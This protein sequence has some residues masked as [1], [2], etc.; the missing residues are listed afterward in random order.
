[1]S[2]HPGGLRELDKHSKN[3]FDRDL[4]LFKFD[5][6]SVEYEVIL[7]DIETAGDRGLILNLANIA[8]SPIYVDGSVIGL[9]LIDPA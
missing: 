6:L 2:S 9:R 5:Y 7:V 4:S 8:L 1:M 3:S